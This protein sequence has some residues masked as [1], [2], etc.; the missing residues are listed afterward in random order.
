MPRQVYCIGSSHNNA[1][2]SPNKLKKIVRDTTAFVKEIQLIQRRK[3]K[4]QINA[5]V[6]SGM[7]GAGVAFPLAMRTGIAPLLV[8]KKDDDSHSTVLVE[9][10]GDLSSDDKINYLIIDDL[11][12]TGA[13]VNY[14]LGSMNKA[15]SN[16]KVQGI[17]LYKN[18]PW[19]KR[20]SFWDEVAGKEIPT[21]S[22]ELGLDSLI[23]A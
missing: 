11:I 5:L 9:G 6:F 21:Y 17:L 4:P 23:T 8:R 10:N 20:T 2:L 12:D 15:C 14:I 3:R 19:D 16:A 1:I 22:V 18:G 7:S 13:T